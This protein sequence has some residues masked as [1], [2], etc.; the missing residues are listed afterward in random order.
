VNAASTSHPTELPYPAIGEASARIPLTSQHPAI[1]PIVAIARTGPNS[2]SESCS[3]EN[4]MLDVMLNVGAQ[5]SAFN[6]ISASTSQRS[7]PHW[8]DAPASAV[9]PAVATASQRSTR[10]G[11]ACR[12]AIAPKTSGES[13]AAMA[14]V[15][16]AKGLIDPSPCESS[17]ALKGTNH[18]PSATP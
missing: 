3:R 14:D 4:A 2:R 17:T 5:H 9:A 6:W 10:T 7:Q 18:M 13:S 15:A 12:S 16:Y 1:Q 11:E 8:M